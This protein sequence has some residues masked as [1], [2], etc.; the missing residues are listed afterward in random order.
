[1]NCAKC[2][3][4]MTHTDTLQNRS[5]V[6]GKKGP[7]TYEYHCAGCDVTDW[8]N[9]VDEFKRAGM[10][11]SYHYA[12]DSTKEWGLARKAERE[13]LRLFDAHPEHQDEMREVA[14]GFLWSLNIERPV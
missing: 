1:M 11:A 10:D 12:D 14:K 9:P 6:T 5:F 13:A 7:A 4:P 8:A 3:E 2:G